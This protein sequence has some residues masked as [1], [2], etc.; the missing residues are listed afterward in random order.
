M[1]A[2]LKLTMAPPRRAPAPMNA[3]SRRASRVVK[4]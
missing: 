3:K 1:S 2:V 4:V